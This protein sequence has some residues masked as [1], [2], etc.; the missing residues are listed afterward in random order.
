MNFGTF[1][2]RLPRRVIDVYQFWRRYRICFSHFEDVFILYFFILSFRILTLTHFFS[3][4]GHFFIIFSILLIEA[5][6]VIQKTSHQFHL[7]YEMYTLIYHIYHKTFIFI[8]FRY[9]FINKKYSK[10]NRKQI[11]KQS[12]RKRY[13]A[14][15]NNDKEENKKK[16]LKKYIKIREKTRMDICRTDNVSREE[17]KKI[18]KTK[19]CDDFLI[20]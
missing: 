1:S 15:N 11:S 14:S 16:A 20:C 2:Q 7:H 5:K 18:L 12:K 10:Q 13:R 4:F 9:T 3:H 8:K 19:F 6:L 17:R